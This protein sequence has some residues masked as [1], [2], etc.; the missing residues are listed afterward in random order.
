VHRDAGAITAHVRFPAGQHT[1]LTM[2]VPK[3]APQQRKTPVEI[4]AA[5]D[6]LLDQHTSGEIADILNQRGLTSGTGETFHRKIVDHIIRTYRLRTRRQRLRQAGMLTPTETAKLLGIS[7][8]TVKAWWR[9]GIVSGLRYNDKG[10]MLYHR[11]D[12]DHP[13]QRPKIG[14]PAKAR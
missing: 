13:P 3:P 6:K 8:Q 7:P 2:P 10:E 12:P 14:R 11:P 1:T 5:I 4:I 9:A